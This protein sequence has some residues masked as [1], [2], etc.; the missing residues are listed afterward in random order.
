M[1]L[2]VAGYANI[3]ERPSEQVQVPEQAQ[4]ALVSARRCGG[5][6]R[7]GAQDATARAS[8][9]YPKALEDYEQPP[10]DDA[11]RAELEEYVTRRRGELGD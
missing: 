10:M 8:G 6:A 7:A 1:M 4:R 5:V 2:R 9:I 3:R 11:V